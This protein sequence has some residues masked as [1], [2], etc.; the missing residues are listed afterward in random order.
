MILIVKAQIGKAGPVV[1]VRGRDA[2]AL[3]ELKAAHDNGCTPIDHPG[4]RWS[5]YVHKL[6]KAGIFIETI[7]E[8]HDGPFSGQQRRY[9]LRSL[10]AIFEMKGGKC[11][12][13]CWPTKRHWRDFGPARTPNPVGSREQSRTGFW[14]VWRVVMLKRRRM[15]KRIDA[16]HVRFYDWLLTSP[17]YLSFGCPARAVLIELT[18]L[19]KGNNNGQLG[20]SVRRASERCNVARG[21]A[22][23]ALPNVRS[24]RSLNWSQG[25]RSVAS[26]HM[27]ANGA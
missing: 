18:R 12:S 8:A 16:P 9:V 6:R 4:P 22:Q 23:R 2:W 19:Y 15:N 11:D 20:L 3:L 13:G 17:A 24:A 27:P 25:A 5:G 26:H 10:I 1:T 14:R 21:T 7:R